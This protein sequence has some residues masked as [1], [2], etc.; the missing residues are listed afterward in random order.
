MR[1][2]LLLLVGIGGLA[3]SLLA[4][5][6]SVLM[7]SAE[8][9]PLVLTGHIRV[10]LLGQNSLWD[11]PMADGGEELSALPQEKSPWLA[12]GFSFIIPGSGQF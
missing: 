8:Q 5:D 3:P 6:G 1:L 4:R 12:A 9:P 10:D 11:H 7:R 2:A